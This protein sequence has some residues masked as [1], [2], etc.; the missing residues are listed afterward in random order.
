MLFTGH[1]VKKS[2]GQGSKSQRNAVLLVTDDGEYVLRRQ[3]GNAF[4]DPQLEGLVGKSIRCQGVLHGYTLLV[5]SCT[6][7]PPGESEQDTYSPAGCRSLT[8]RKPT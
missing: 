6:E 4:H 1:V 5:S 7:V 2:F 8:D 3:G